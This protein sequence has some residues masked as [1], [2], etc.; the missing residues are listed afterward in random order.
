MPVL[1]QHKAF[2]YLIAW[3]G[4]KEVGS[5]EVRPGVEPSSAQLAAVVARQASHP[6]RMVLRPAYQY[7]T[8]SRWVSA[9]AKIP[10]VTLPFTVGGTPEAKDLFALYDDTVRRLLQ[11]LP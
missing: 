7:D 11:A 3:L 1:V 9:Q 6:A 2:P 8:P 5:L 10:A 4:M